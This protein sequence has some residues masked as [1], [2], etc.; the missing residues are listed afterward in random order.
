[1]SSTLRSGPRTFLDNSLLYLFSYDVEASMDRQNLGFVPGGVRVNVFAR[2]NL[3]GVYHVMREATIA[4]L[5]FQT[6]SGSLTWGGD[7][8]LW[9]ED[10]IEFT[11]VRMTIQTDDDATI[12]AGYKATTYLGPGGFRRLV[13]GK[14][15]VGTDDAPVHVPLIT[16]P[17]FETTSPTYRW[18]MDYQCIGFGRVEIIKS[19]IRRITYD[20]YALT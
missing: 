13:S 14:G 18:L 17:R 19:E 1:V 3:S 7:W 5:G 9:R 8:L 4:G 2:P 16:S 15:K 12:Y 20:V 6:I 10:D 11:E